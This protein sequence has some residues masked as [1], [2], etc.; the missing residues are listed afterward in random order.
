MNYADGLT[1]DEHVQLLRFRARHSLNPV[2]TSNEAACTESF[3]KSLIA[4]R[5][6]VYCQAAW[7]VL[8]DAAVTEVSL[9]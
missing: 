2:F 9:A 6:S 7:D 1:D 5:A 8:G 4:S 3:C